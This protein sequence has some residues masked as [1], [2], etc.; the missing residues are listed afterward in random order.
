MQKLLSSLVAQTYPVG[1]KVRETD[2]GLP[3][4]G[5]WR[6]LLLYDRWPRRSITTQGALLHLCLLYV[7]PEFLLWPLL[8]G[9]IP[10]MEFWGTW[11]DLA[12][13]AWCRVLASFPLPALHLCTS[14]SCALTLCWETEGVLCFCLM[15][16]AVRPTANNASTCFLSGMGSLFC[17][18]DILSSSIHLPLA[19]YNLNNF[20]N[21]SYFRW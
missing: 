10:G 13:L 5:E 20:F 9:Y 16:C 6:L 14:Y 4:H 12:L 18:E 2:G 8:P 11:F 3:G 21:T 7:L 19:I 15:R 1:P 17:C